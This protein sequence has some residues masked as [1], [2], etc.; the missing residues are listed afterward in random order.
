MDR[1][2]H[3]LERL[4]SKLA[5]DYH[6]PDMPPP[7]KPKWMRWRTYSRIA[8]QIEAGQERLDVVF[9]AGAQRLLA[10]ADRSKQRR[11]MRR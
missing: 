11:R 6:G 5:A 7:R 10:R 2:H 3:R 9:C 8:Q 1:A 4:H